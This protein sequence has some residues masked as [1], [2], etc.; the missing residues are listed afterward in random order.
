MKP[1]LEFLFYMLVLQTG[2]CFLTAIAFVSAYPFAGPSAAGFMETAKFLFSVSG[3]SAVIGFFC[4][5]AH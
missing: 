4:L 3:A 2:V 5:V 1:I